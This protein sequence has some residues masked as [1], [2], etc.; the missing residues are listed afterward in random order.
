MVHKPSRVSIVSRCPHK[1]AVHLVV[2]DGL[3]EMTER[4]AVFVDLIQEHPL[5]IQ[6]VVDLDGIVILLL[7]KGTTYK[8]HDDDDLTLIR[9]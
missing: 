9:L 5:K 3:H 1:E 8:Y 2:I 7:V 6:V 4:L